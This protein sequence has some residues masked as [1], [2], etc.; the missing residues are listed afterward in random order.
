L[1]GYSSLVRD[2][3][4]FERHSAAKRGTALR[5]A[6][7]MIITTASSWEKRPATM[8][9]CAGMMRECRK[10]A[11]PPFCRGSLETRLLEA[12][13]LKPGRAVLN[14][15]AVACLFLPGLFGR[16]SISVF[17]VVYFSIDVASRKRIN[18]INSQVRYRRSPVGTSLPRLSAAIVA[19]YAFRIPHAQKLRRIAHSGRVDLSRP[20]T[21]AGSGAS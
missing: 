16:V 3:S 5:F 9:A 15:R 17:S 11:Q 2:A 14:V 20:R 7:R 13:L 10:L 21:T 12:S 19:P 6:E 18:E 4:N 1:R 8:L